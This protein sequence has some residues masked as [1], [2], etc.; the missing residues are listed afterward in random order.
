MAAMITVVNNQERAHF[1][2][3]GWVVVSDVIDRVT[4]AT[5]RERLAAIYPSEG[6]VDA[7]PVRHA[8]VADGQF[9][10]LRF[11]PVD[12]LMLDLLPLDPRLLGFVGELLGPGDVRLLRAGYQA[13]YAGTVDFDQVHH[14]DYPNHSLVVPA[15]DDIV[16][17]F[18]FL[19]DVTV[20]L[21]PTMLVSDAFCPPVDPGRTHVDR[22]SGPELYAVEEAALGTAGSVLAYRATT[23]HRGSAIAAA[24]GVRLT[25]GFAFGRP[26]P[27]TGFQSIPRM[28][29]DDALVAALSAAE[30]AQRA[31]LGFPPPGDRYWTP[32]TIAL[33]ARRYP[34]L[35]L[36]PYRTST[37]TS[38][39]T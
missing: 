25:L 9:G 29:E 20:D 28:G 6:D 11:W 13:K 22:A 2:T 24:Q 39:P 12:D 8:W 31:V 15:P 26:N 38:G 3:H 27:W 36:S 37:V 32:E 19:S 30:P 23:Y 1:R 18:L 5:A 17:F 7:D 33:V 34:D 10:G 35:D 16:G 14:V 4:V 21:G